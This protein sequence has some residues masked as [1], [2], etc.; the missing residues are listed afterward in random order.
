MLEYHWND[1]F[2]GYNSGLIVPNSQWV[3]VALVVQPT[4]ATLYMNAG[5]GMQ[6]ATNVAAHTVRPVLNA[7]YIGWDNFNANRRWYGKVDETMIFDRALTPAQIDA[8]Y[9]GTVI[10]RPVPLTVTRSGNNLTLSWPNGTLQQADEATGAY[11][12]MAGVTSPYNLS[13]SG[14]KKFY[15]VRVQ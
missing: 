5:A 8:L 10:P 13:P 2:S 7:G 15:R 4:K 6:S 11:T 1:G 3:F 14:S 9:S 12:D